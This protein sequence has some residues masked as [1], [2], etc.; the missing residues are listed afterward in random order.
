MRKVV[1]GTYE[2]CDNT[3]RSMSFLNWGLPRQPYKIATITKDERDIKTRVYCREFISESAD[4]LEETLKLGVACSIFFRSA[5]T[6]LKFMIT[7]T[8]VLSATRIRSQ[9]SRHGLVLLMLHM[10]REVLWPSNRCCV[11]SKTVKLPEPVTRAQVSLSRLRTLH[12]LFVSYHL[13]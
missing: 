10:H 2:I 13:Y 6:D 5:Q 4:R 3:G 7:G 8:Y 1:N 9:Q 11:L 12:H